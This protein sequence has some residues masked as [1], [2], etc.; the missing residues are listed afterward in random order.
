[1]PDYS[2]RSREA[3]GMQVEV[4][5]LGGFDVRVNG[6]SIPAT[7]WRRR[8]AAALVKLLAMSPGRTMHR[9]QVI[10]APWPD[11]PLHE[12]GPRLHKAAHFARR[13]CGDPGALVLSGERVSFFP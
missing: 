5:L 8:Q 10:D 7:E 6:T 9:E 2:P 11:A 4:Q 3:D 13:S 1:M 12:A